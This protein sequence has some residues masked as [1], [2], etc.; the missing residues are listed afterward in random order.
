MVETIF[1]VLVFL[2]VLAIVLSVISTVV[3]GFGISFNG[4]GATLSSFLSVVCYM[5]PIKRLL[6]VVAC[7]IGLICLRIVVSII[8]S[9]FAILPLSL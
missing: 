1:R 4:F 5:L 7:S 8:R 6:P 9:V 3:V 2:V